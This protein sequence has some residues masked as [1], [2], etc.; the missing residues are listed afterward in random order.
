MAPVRR[1]AGSK[2]QGVNRTRSGNGVR[3]VSTSD[4]TMEQRV[5][6]NYYRNKPHF[7]K[8]N[9]RSSIGTHNRHDQRRTAERHKPSTRRTMKIDRSVKHKK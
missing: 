6:S 9:I 3:A 1:S 8:P 4:G 5:H 2:Q 7:R